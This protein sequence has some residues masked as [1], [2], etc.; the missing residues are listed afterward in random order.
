MFTPE[1]LMPVIAPF[2]SPMTMRSLAR[3]RAFIA[4]LSSQ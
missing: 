1:S 2:V 4:L 3:A